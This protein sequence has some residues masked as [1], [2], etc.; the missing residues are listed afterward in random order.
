VAPRPRLG[1]IRLTLRASPPC[2]RTPGPLRWRD[3]SR[4][5][6]RISAATTAIRTEA[7]TKRYG[8][9]VGVEEL[10]LSVRT[11]EIFG[12]LGPNG[13]GKSTTIR[14]LLD[15]IRPT[16]G[17]AEVLGLDPRADGVGL[18]RRIGYLP[19]E[20]ALPDDLTVG[21]TLRW[22]AALRGGVDSAVIEHLCE[23]FSLD[24]TRRNRALS[25]GNRQ[26]VGLVVAFMG[27]PDLLIL[28]EPT[29]GLDPLIQHEFNRLVGEVR[30]EGRTIFL[31]SH[32]LDEVEAVADRVGII[33]RGRLVAVDTIEDL[34]ARTA[35]KVEIRFA[36][37]VPPDVFADLPGVQAAE[38][39]GPIVRLLVDGDMDAL[40]KAAARHEVVT[41][42]S[43]EPDLEELFLA[44]YAEE[45]ED[46][47]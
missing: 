28:D 4:E 47:P 39:E 19:G 44:H 27:E 40:V 29:R 20:L 31:S 2:A 43:H 17:A 10:D 7:L 32:I 23:R 25:T 9:V 13:A 26:K 33:R 30:A 12:F 45:A 37:T 6:I 3:V 11:G 15:L 16:S 5:G 35:R 24:R 22:Y 14:C 21:Q 46:A 42:T 36:S 18:R 38:G 34:R 1:L 41:L 8:T